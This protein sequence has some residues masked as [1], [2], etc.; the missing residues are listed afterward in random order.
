M[1]QKI[2]ERIQGMIAW[3]VIILIAVTF[4]LFGVDY[5]MQS[6]QA[7]DV[8]VTVNGEDVGKQTYEINYRRIRQQREYEQVTTSNDSALKKQVLEDMIVNLITVQSANKEGFLVSNGQANGAIVNIPQF[9]QDGQFSTERYQQ[10]LSAA[11]YTPETFQNQ[12]RQGMLLNQQRFAFMGGAFALPSEIN[13]FVKLYM[14]TRDYDY[15][16]I[17]SQQFI[18]T[19]HVS[20]VDLTQYYEKHKQRFI[21]PEKVSIDYIRLSMQHIKDQTKINEA[22]VQRYY[23]DNETNFLTPVQWQVETIS[24]AVPKNATLDQKNEMKQKAYAVYQTVQKNPALFAQAKIQAAELSAGQD[25]PPTDAV[26]PWIVAGTTQYDKVLARLTTVGA[27]SAPFKTEKGY[28]I[29]KLIAYKKATLK[30]F[31]AV[32]QEIRTQ[33]AAELAEA[34][35]MGALEQLTD[36]SYQ[37]PDSLAPVASALKLP[38]LKTPLFSHDGANSP[39]AQN[40]QVVNAAF[41]HDVLDLGNNSEP[42]QLSNDTVIVL[43]VNKHISAT[44]KKLADVQDQITQKLTLIAARTAAKNFGQTLLDTSDRVK[45]QEIMTQHKLVWHSVNNAARDSDDSDALVSALAFN[46]PR[47]N[48]QEGRSLANGNYVIVR[49][50]ALHDGQYQMLDKEQQASLVQQIEASYGVMDYDLYIN[51]LVAAAKIDRH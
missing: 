16:I 30:P 36:L 29:V 21:E 38:V 42:V 8:E 50:N 22:D 25:Q 3:I 46:L 14:Q 43:R 31:N 10:A 24:F 2:N 13:R 26:L 5:Y 1:L 45:E 32:K 37:T 19:V 6:R 17:P 35:Y 47:V 48:S 23:Q 4:T 7:S 9:Q 34:H 28:E 40:K 12:V 41:S 44:Q 11:M 20:S 27:I 39:F 15:L 18:N 51:S 33:L 49:L